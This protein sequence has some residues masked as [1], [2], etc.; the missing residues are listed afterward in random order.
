MSAPSSVGPGKVV[1]IHYT[2]RGETGEVLDSSDS[3]E[4][5]EYLHGASNIVVGLEEGLLGATPGQKVRVKVAPEKG[6]GPRAP[7]A[8]HAFPRDAFPADM[9]IE[10]G[11]SFQAEGEDGQSLPVWVLSVEAEQVMVDFNHPLAGHTLDFEVTIDGLRDAT[12]EEIAH[13]HPHGPGGHHHH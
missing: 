6:Y 8:V 12:S 13:G 4:P 3:S 2:L 11:M 7:D 9:P 5:L 10:E 1:R